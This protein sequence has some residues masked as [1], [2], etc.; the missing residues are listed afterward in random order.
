M[1][2]RAPLNLDGG[3]RHEG[4]I[5]QEILAKDRSLSCLAPPRMQCL[6]QNCGAG[7]NLTPLKPNAGLNGPPGFGWTSRNGWW[8]S[9]LGPRRYRGCFGPFFDAASGPQKRKSGLHEL[10]TS[11]QDV[12]ISVALSDPGCLLI[13]RQGRPGASTS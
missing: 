2:K 12:D 5:A 11:F 10:V 1:P 3:R 13:F 6:L 8:H 9:R 7:G 4:S